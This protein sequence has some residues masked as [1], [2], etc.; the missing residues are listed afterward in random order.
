MPRI[1]KINAHGKTAITMLA[2]ASMLLTGCAQFR[3][4][5]DDGHVRESNEQVSR[6]DKH[7]SYPSI[8]RANFEQVNLIEMIDPEGHAKK[9]YAN[10]WPT[11]GEK[12]GAKYDL[13]FSGFRQRT[14]MSDEAKRQRR[15][16]VQDKIIA[17]STSRCNV[18]KTFLR[19][20][21]AD[22][23][24][25]LGSATT[26][27]GV[28][29][30]LL[31]GARDVRNLA[32]VA[33]ILS[34]V[35]AEFNQSYYSNLTAQVI[36]EGI[37]L[38]Q[39][40]IKEKLY[41]GGREKSVADYTLEAAIAD[42]L[43]FDGSC[44]ALTG[45]IVAQDSIQ[46]VTRPGPEAALNAMLYAQTMQAASKLDMSTPDIANKIEALRK[47]PG[48]G[49][50]P[51]IV[52]M[53]HKNSASSLGDRSQEAIRIIENL[54]LQIQ[55]Q[56][57]QLGNR[58]AETLVQFADGKRGSV[59]AQQVREAFA[60]WGRD[61]LLTPLTAEKTGDAPIC[62]AA[63]TRTMSAMAASASKASLT[64][65]GSPQRLTASKE[66]AHAEADASMQLGKVQHLLDVNT[67]QLSKARVAVEALVTS[68]A[69]PDDANPFDLKKMATVLSSIAAPALAKDWK[70]DTPQ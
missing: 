59:T 56:S 10:L 32:G 14:D 65:E 48:Q 45:L 35:Q 39:S 38:R 12:Y 69:T 4:A 22:G 30:A 34:G 42:G 2:A 57:D 5:S 20:Q 9:I 43:V 8:S 36:I 47:I 61:A 44:S 3:V 27:A 52:S 25:Y 41:S 18:F 6:V 40:Q 19:R 63:V 31:P 7:S 51:L 21:Q 60:A 66:L 1:K 13:A 50:Q 26:V 46:Q 15:N 62:I 28:L 11:E 68:P 29:G 58:Y 67:A 23:N 24:F 17:V 49:P 70:C 53:V 54:S 37:E 33:G 64:P 16:G 55:R